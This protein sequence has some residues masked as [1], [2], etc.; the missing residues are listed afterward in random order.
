VRSVALLLLWLKRFLAENLAAAVNAD[1]AN[2][3]MV[4]PKIP[5]PSK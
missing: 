5:K 2:G 3:E 1:N 4:L